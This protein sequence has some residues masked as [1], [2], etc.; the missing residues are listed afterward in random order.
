MNRELKAIVC[1][2]F[3]TI[4]AFFVH[5]VITSFLGIPFVKDTNAQY[6]TALFIGGLT[7]AFIYIWIF[8]KSGQ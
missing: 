1:A 6:V 4:L 3:A 7:S 2:V 5:L 8:D